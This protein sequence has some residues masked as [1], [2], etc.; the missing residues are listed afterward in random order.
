MFGRKRKEITSTLSI[1]ELE[2]TV[3]RKAVKNINIR[4]NRSTGAIRVSCPHQVRD[5][6]LQKFLEQKL[7]WIRKHQS[8]KEIR[9]Q[10]KREFTFVEGEEHLFK[11]EIFRL[12]FVENVNAN[13]IVFEDGELRLG[14]V[15]KGNTVRLKKLI[16]D[17]HRGYL[18][19]QIPA[20][21]DKWEPI[22]GVHVAEFGVKKMKT[23][24]GTCNIR[25]HRIWLS[26]ELAKKSPELL[27][28]VVVHEMV[29]L[30]ERLHNARFKAFMTQYLPHWPELDKQLNG[31]MC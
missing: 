26:L 6:D 22:M 23:R 27:E 28:Y 24:W 5:R 29:H 4:V 10:A 12:R 1:K 30:H 8:A 20:L 21:I 14:S 18:K 19:Q 17:F 16:E 7:S 2:V 13:F 31:K 11:G 3:T 15:L 25:A 9:Q